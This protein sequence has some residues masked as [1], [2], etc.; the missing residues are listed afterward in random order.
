[1]NIARYLVQGVDVWLNNPRRPKEA[2]GTSGM[3]VIYNGGLNLSTLDGWWD[4]GYDPAF[5][6][7]IGNGEEYPES[8]EELQDTIEAKALYNLLEQD[9]VPLFYERSRDGLP[10]EWISR[11][12]S[13]MKK[14]A[15]FF[16]TTRMVIEY[17]QKYYMPA[18]EGYLHLTQPDLARGVSFATWREHLDS[19]WPEVKV[20]KVETSTANELKIG[21]EQEVNAWV[22]L[23]TLMPQDVTVQ[24]YHGVLN[25]R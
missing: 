16:N 9:V 12:K 11:V 7:A 13:S 2:S 10:R 4:E 14:L 18:Y 8:Q 24:L 23:G 25:S 19:V 22:H 15:P 20:T 1:M 5:G 6:W 3:K 21:S 17:T